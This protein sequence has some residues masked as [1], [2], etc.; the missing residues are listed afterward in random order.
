MSS[1][2]LSTL[3]WT[4]MAM[5]CL[6][7]LRCLSSPAT[8]HILLPP[9]PPSAME[10]DRSGK[11]PEI[12]LH[13]NEYFVSHGVPHQGKVPADEVTDLDMLGLADD[14]IGPESEEDGMI[15]YKRSSQSEGEGHGEANHRQKRGIVIN[16][17]EKFWT[18]GY[19]PYVM[20]MSKLSEKDKTS[21][22]LCMA[23]MEQHTC[24]RFIPWNSTT[25]ALY[26]LANDG[27]LKFTHLYACSSQLGN[28]Y[29]RNKDGQGI[30]CCF[31]ATCIHELGHALGLRHEHAHYDKGVIRRDWLKQSASQIPRY[32]EIQEGEAR[33]TQ[34]DFSSPMHYSMDEIKGDV[35]VLF[36][37]LTRSQR[38]MYFF[39]LISDTYQCQARNCSSSHRECH[40]AGF[41]TMVNGRCDCYCPHGLDPSTGCTTVRTKYEK[42]T[43]PG[44]SYALPSPRDGCPQSHGFQTRVVTHTYPHLWDWGTDLLTDSLSGG[45]MTTALCTRNSRKLNAMKWPPGL[46]CIYRVGDCPQGFEY[47]NMTV[48]TESG[49]NSGHF[50]GID[51]G[52]NYVV[53]HFCCRKEGVLE[54]MVMPNTEPYVLLRQSPWGCQQIA[55]MRSV[56]QSYSVKDPKAHKLFSGSV[57]YQ[58]K[59]PL[60]YRFANGETRFY[61]CYYYPVTDNPFSILPCEDSHHVDCATLAHHGHCREN[62]VTHDCPYSCDTCPGSV[63]VFGECVDHDPDCQPQRCPTYGKVKQAACKFTCRLCP[64]FCGGIVKLTRS[65]PSRE[66][67][68]PYF[69]DYYDNN[70]DCFWQITGPPGSTLVLTFSSFD[71]EGSP[72]KCKDKLEV[73]H[74]RLDH[75]GN[76]YCG[77]DFAMTIRSLYNEME[78]RL[79]TDYENEGHGFNATVRLAL[80]EDHCFDPSRQG[81]D[82]RGTVGYTR[83]WTPC[84]PWNTTRHCRHHAYAPYDLRD[85]LRDNF[86]RNPGNGMRPW[87]YINDQCDRNYCDVCFL[88]TPYDTATDCA[89]FKTAGHCSVDTVQARKK[90]ARTCQAELPPRTKPPAYTTVKCGPPS[91]PADAASG[92][93]LKTEYSVGEN[94]SFTCQNDA[95]LNHLITCLPNGQWSALGYVCG[96]CPEGWTF[97]DN[98]CFLESTTAMTYDK[99][100]AHCL[101]LQAQVAEARTQEDMRFLVQLKDDGREQWMGLR[102]DGKSC[103]RWKD[104]T[105]PSWTKWDKDS[106]V[107][108]N[109]AV[110]TPSL[111]WSTRDCDDKNLL[112]VCQRP[113]H[114]SRVCADFLPDCTALVKRDPSACQEPD[115]AKFSCP[116]TCYGTTN[117]QDPCASSP[118]LNGGKC[119]VRGGTFQCACSKNYNGTRCEQHE[120]QQNSC[121]DE[122]CDCAIHKVNGYCERKDKL[123]HY[124][125]KHCPET[126]GICH[127]QASSCTDKQASCSGVNPG[128]CAA[129]SSLVDSCR[130]SCG[131]CVDG[132][133]CVDHHASCGQWVDR[134]LCDK[135][136]TVR[137]LC[138]HGCNLCFNP[139]CYDVS[140]DCHWWAPDYC[141]NGFVLSHCSYGCHRCSIVFKCYKQPCKNNGTCS[142]NSEA[143]DGYTCDCSG[144]GFQGPT[145]EQRQRLRSK[146]CATPDCAIAGEQWQA[147]FDRKARARC[148]DGWKLHEGSC[149]KYH[150]KRMTYA[151]AQANCSSAVTG[152]KVAT[153]SSS[154]EN[155]MIYNM[156]EH[157]SVWVDARRS[158]GDSLFRWSSGGLVSAGYSNWAPR[159]P[160]NDD[161]DCAGIRKYDGRWIVLPC[162]KRRGYVC[163]VKA[164]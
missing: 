75:Q 105:R 26:G 29:A 64:E 21:I 2:S 156:T 139:S 123:R 91:P 132:P 74:A 163:K 136:S 122:L 125:L 18:N 92:Y 157:K 150:V 108:E 160:V 77:K 33:F 101:S 55:G 16:E 128:D 53:F 103:F 120:V 57:G 115:F 147:P 152:A 32:A 36:P 41:V 116:K 19:V 79:H 154:S 37:E 48:E 54:P 85:D 145:C 143:A 141:D 144:T 9:P 47:S 39:R 146:R 82:Y 70:M 40:N 52:L 12:H 109:C 98:L 86:C 17:P 95:N 76:F 127:G 129:N 7:P 164:S 155:E 119:Y 62:H 56:E 134:D 35:T 100:S 63:D 87:C 104:K 78:M 97:H 5:L 159:Q 121:Q 66:I 51:V 23:F 44:G 93:S 10:S 67:T 112:F 14:V 118:C 130:K 20:D 153:I 88:E 148:A 59:G 111:S 1:P 133:N 61:S 102:R 106:D 15:R 30:M 137:G 89:E 13:R 65:N 142:E 49:G 80:P 162:D 113:A 25:K 81:R 135:N 140:Y 149:Y 50:P 46:Y 43:F 107:D 72:S 24:I 68:S 42:Q 69:P 161:K 94:V 22:S 117:C 73:N 114:N 124:V 11:A 126:C 58:D 158:D 3:Q 151:D 60:V 6:Q 28:D 8:G 83:D 99:A 131:L 27:H 45:R 34:F 71:V 90:C 96:G 31:P 84:V 138:P 110:L 38:Y 4:L